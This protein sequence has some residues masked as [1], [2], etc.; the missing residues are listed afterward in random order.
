LHHSPLSAGLLFTGLALLGVAAVHDFSFRTVPNLLCAALLLCGVALRLMGADI[1]YGL[2]AGA[3]V[4]T[5][6]TLAWR[7]GWLGGGDVKLLGASAVFV[8]PALVPALMLYTS[9]AGGVLAMIYLVAGRL[10]PAPAASRPRHLVAR[11][12]R[13]ELW[14]LRRRGPLPYAA[15]IAAGGI[16]ATLSP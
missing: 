6:C 1:G 12:A 4:F 16:C 2:L 13:C 7:F 8:A 11:I 10:V 15:A 5:L 14:R 9:L 3:I